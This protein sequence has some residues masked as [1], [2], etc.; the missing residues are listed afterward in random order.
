MRAMSS[1]I[2]RIA[3]RLG[4][5]PAAQAQR[6][7]DDAARAA[8]RRVAAVASRHQRSLLAALTTADVS[9][10]QADGLHINASTSAGLAVVRARSR[11]AAWNNGYAKRYLGMVGRNVLGPM[12]VRYQARVRT[13]AGDLR[14][15]VNDRLEAAWKAWGRRGV[16][17]VTG[18][19][20]WRAFERLA[21]RSTAVDGECFVRLFPGRGPHA[22]QLQL[23]P[24]D[25]LPIDYSA[26]IGNGR[27]I[28]QGVE[29][30]A[31]GA[32]L[33]Y[34][35][36]SGDTTTDTIGLALGGASQRLVRVPA[37]DVIHL[38]LPLEVNQLRGVPWMATALKRLYQAQDFAAAGLNKAR[39]SAKRGGFLYEDPEGPGADPEHLADG[40]DS[41]GN[42]YAS[43]HDGTW[44]KLPPGLRPE[45]FSNEYPNIEYGQFIKDCLRD[46]ASS[47]DVAYIT[48][49][50][51]LEDVNYSSGQLGMEGERTMWLELQQ[52]FVDELVDRVHRQ[53]LRHALLAAPELQPLDYSRL[54]QYADA[55]LWQC[56]RWHP[57]DPL[58]TVEAQ[59]SRIE[60]RLTS[61][62]RV[63]AE[64]GDDPDEI[65]AELAE[66][67]E[68]TKGLP[69]VVPTKPAA[70]GASKP[71]DPA[72]AEDDGSAARR[73]L[74]LRLIA[75]RSDD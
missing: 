29:I 38:V 64:M 2:T 62:Q 54:E 33:A 14:K 74:R 47:L 6:A 67:V 18:R 44:E 20:T 5:T 69:P 70:S 39:E 16:C 52:W 60:A 75:N 25:A 9:S 73:E 34:H 23:L 40:T 10:W 13:Q 63:I 43:L 15:P 11:D 58:K 48:F 65:V 68:K 8:G 57:L 27:R 42:A 22:L 4:Y 56:H 71:D 45:A 49:G 59:R 28:R 24:A 72:A 17:E 37:E 1:L 61:P 50:N 32:V 55:A 46:A 12:G 35:F 21:L 53:W 36:R 30:D 31:A 26:D 7:A 66:W 19:Y 51:S 3:A 41:D